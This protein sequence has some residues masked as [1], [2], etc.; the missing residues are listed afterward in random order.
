MRRSTAV[1]FGV[2][3]LLVLVAVTTIVVARRP[4]EPPTTVGAASAEQL[5]APTRSTDA[6]T[7]GPDPGR[8]PVAPQRL[9]IPDIGVDAVVLPVGVE[10]DTGE[11]EVPRAVDR[12]GWYRY[13]PALDAR[14]GSTV[15]AGHVDDA[16][17][18]EGAFFELR[19][20]GIGDRLTIT[21]TDG[22]DRQYRLVAREVFDKSA[23]PLDRL[24]SREGEP[25]LTLVTCGGSFDSATRSYRDNIVV[26]AVEEAGP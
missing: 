19:N 20:L 24:F 10:P 12:V 23:V 5:A 21:G 14:A 13:G 6:P 26:T 17:Q 25:R 15:I 1:A 18:G 2:G 7:R 16:D 8:V 3:V 22:T 9:R 11:M 4:A